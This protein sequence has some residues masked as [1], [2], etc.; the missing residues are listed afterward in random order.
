[1]IGSRLRCIQVVAALSLAG[2]G[3][4]GTG[5]P[6]STSP[7][8]DASLTDAQ[9]DATDDS[10][11]VFDLGGPQDLGVVCDFDALAADGPEPTDARRTC[12][13]GREAPS[14]PLLLDAGIT[15]ACETCLELWNNDCFGTVGG[16]LMP[17]ELSA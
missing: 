5:Q 8:T 9:R 3:G 7:A 13:C 1:M 14:D 16:P 6:T 10:S 15:T 17:P 2:C 4:G 11:P 12:R